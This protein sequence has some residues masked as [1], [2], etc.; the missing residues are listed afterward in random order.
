MA[1]GLSPKHISS[2]QDVAVHAGQLNSLAPVAASDASVQSAHE[3]SGIG[4]I[5]PD[6]VMSASPVDMPPVLLSTA[7]SIDNLRLW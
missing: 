5:P 3:P 7:V 2:A 1:S 4:G 6:A